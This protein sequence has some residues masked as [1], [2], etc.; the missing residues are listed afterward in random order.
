M[1]PLPETIILLL[2][3]LTL[4]FSGRVWRHGRFFLLGARLTPGACTVTTPLRAMRLAT[5]RRF[6]SYHRVLN[7]ATWSARQAAGVS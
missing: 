2:A 4:L 6:T 5:E 1:L 3:P 7:R